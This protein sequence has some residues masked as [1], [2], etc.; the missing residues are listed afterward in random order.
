MTPDITLLKK[1]LREETKSFL[2]RMRTDGFY[3]NDGSSV[4][5]AG[6]KR[7]DATTWD[8]N[9]GSCEDFADAVVDCFSKSFPGADATWA[10]DPELHPFDE[11]CQVCDKPAFVVSPQ[12]HH[13]GS[14]GNIDHAADKNHDAFVGWEPDHCVVEYRGK[15]Y[16]AECH[17]G[18]DRVR[19]LP[20]YKNRGKTRTQVI[21]EQRAE[22][23]AQKGESN[24]HRKPRDATDRAPRASMVGSPRTSASSIA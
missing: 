2:T 22:K 13:H 12:E 8:I 9:C 24:A 4:W 6:K 21:R 11:N 1:I 17:E 15:F 20:I 16:D 19:D 7:H 3:T 14:P 10:H 5:R 23:R 18:V